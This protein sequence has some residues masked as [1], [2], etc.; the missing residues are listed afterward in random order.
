MRGRLFGVSV[1]CIALLLA[2]C[3]S[4]VKSSVP[5]GSSTTATTI[6]RS[7]VL[8]PTT[9]V[10]ARALASGPVAHATDIA[11]GIAAAGL[12]CKNASLDSEVPNAQNDTVGNPAKESV[13]CDIGEDITTITLYDD[14]AK[15]E[16]SMSFIRQSTCYTHK[17]QP[18][19]LSY[20]AGDNWIV[21]PQE[22]ATAQRVAS[23]LRASLES[24]TC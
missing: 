11:A 10:Q 23:A 2:S 24:V 16:S 12:G 15:L 20:A 13:S 21:F 6:E 5:P 19:N 17:Q 4:S 3:S 14:H 18:T 7:P 8:V 22:K 9:I 1:G